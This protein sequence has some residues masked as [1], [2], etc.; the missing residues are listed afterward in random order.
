MFYLGYVEIVLL[1]TGFIQAQNRIF[2]T[3]HLECSMLVII[4]SI[5]TE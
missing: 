3:K 5:K 4:N 2:L 1:D